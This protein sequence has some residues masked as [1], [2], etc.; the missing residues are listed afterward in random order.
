MSRQNIVHMDVY[1]PLCL[2]AKLLMVEHVAQRPSDDLESCRVTGQLEYR[3]I[4]GKRRETRGNSAGGL[5]L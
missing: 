3:G 5:V 4:G 1:M 2:R